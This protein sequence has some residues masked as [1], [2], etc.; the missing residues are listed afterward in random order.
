MY[1]KGHRFGKKR[2]EEG[3][4]ILPRQL[5][6]SGLGARGGGGSAA[7][8]EPTPSVERSG[9]MENNGGTLPT[10]DTRRAAG[11]S[12]LPIN[13]ISGEGCEIPACT[14]TNPNTDIDHTER[15]EQLRDIFEEV[16]ARGVYNMQ[17]ARRRVPSGLCI[18]AWR[19]YLHDYED[20]NLV[21]CLAFGWPIDFQRSAP[22][23]PTDFNH[24]SARQFSEH[25]DFYIQTELGWGALAGPFTEPPVS[26]FHSSPLMTRPKKD[27]EK[28]R[29]IVDLS[30]PEGA[31]INDGIQSDWY[32]DRP[33]SIS[34]P[35][36]DYME[37]RLLSLGRGAY[38]YKT[39]LAR[40]YRQLRVDPTDWPLLGFRHGGMYYMDLCPP[41]GLRTSALFM[42]RTSEAIC[43]I[44][45]KA[46]YR[47][48]PYLDDF[49]GAESTLTE[50]SAAMRTLQNIMR[51]LGVQEAEHKACGPA[52]QI[53]WLG[54][55]YDSIKMTI[56]IPPAKMEEI[57]ALL[58][59]WRGR[60][61]ATLHQLQSLIGTLQF[62]A[63]VSPPTRIFTNRM[64]QCLRE[65]HKHG[66]ESLSWGFKR[67]L[68]FFLTLLPRFNGVK[69]IAKD[70]IT[71][72]DQLEWTRA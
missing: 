32:L 25:V 69:I 29:V 36:V 13:S 55:L 20:P 48:R 8:I 63:G 9:L 68:A 51:E 1:Q 39:D 12:Q 4:G 37:Q 16:T 23:Q 65:A 5:K 33:A 59:D 64:L 35:T 7:V 43:H 6:Y 44:H 2:K 42:Q 66:S 47:S 52:Q 21:D 70:D 54:L 24:P 26:Y 61:R 10:H 71:Y 15:N 40:G 62:V 30:W 67:D 72:Q 17:G 46:G 38:I 57:M 28:R 50:A 34:L 22:L 11:G 18:E 53:V 58:R 27:S 3:V 60:Q 14:T 45:A 41:F 19:H 31:S 56:S 49:G